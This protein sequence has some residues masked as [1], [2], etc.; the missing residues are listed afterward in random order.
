MESPQHPKGQLNGRGNHRGSI[1]RKRVGQ[2]I[3]NKAELLGETRSCPTWGEG[4]TASAAISEAESS[5]EVE[6][7]SYIGDMPFLWLSVDDAPGK[8]SSRG[9][10]ERNCIGLLSNVNKP[11]VDLPSKGWL[12][13]SSEQGTIRESGLWNTDCVKETYD[14]AFLKRLNLFIAGRGRP[15]II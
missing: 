3:L 13:R 10:L 11:V 12:G 6:V 4:S 5:L 9:F 2:A 15:M 14:P 7:S 8:A 1:F